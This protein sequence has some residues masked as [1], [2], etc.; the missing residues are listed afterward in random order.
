MAFELVAG[1][2]AKDFVLDLKLCRVLFE[3][4]KYYP[5]IHAVHSPQESPAWGDR[6]GADT[7]ALRV[8]HEEAE[9]LFGPALL[10]ERDAMLRSYLLWQKGV[11]DRILYSLRRA[12]DSSS[13]VM[14]KKAQILRKDELIR[15]ALDYFDAE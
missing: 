7:E 1:L 13:S 12:N 2:A 4:N 3:D 14:D 9:D 11:N 10:R 5:V 6:P 8:L 15:A